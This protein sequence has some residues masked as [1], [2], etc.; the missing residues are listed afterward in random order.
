MEIN[1]FCVGK[2]A[3]KKCIV[4]EK[5]TLSRMP[6]ITAHDT[7]IRFRC[8]FQTA[9]KL[10]LNVDKYSKILNMV[11]NYTQQV[12]KS[13]KAA[14][15][16]AVNDALDLLVK[17]VN[18]LGDDEDV[19]MDALATKV[20]A[21]FKG[22]LQESVM[23]TGGKGK[24]NGKKAKKEKDENAPKAPLTAFFC[25]ASEVR[26]KIRAER[27]ELKMVEV[28]KEISE[29]WKKLDEKQKE[30]YVAMATKDKERYEAQ[31]KD[32]VKA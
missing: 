7:V 20:K 8:R 27:P 17:E 26:P 1:I 15:L 21:H 16:S 9:N 28:S 12:E 22:L 32:Y 30:A 4:Y 23:A 25:F 14:L 19:N 29:M 18:S 11:A 31:K 10:T 3:W 24:K 2:N 5:M 13:L 6:I